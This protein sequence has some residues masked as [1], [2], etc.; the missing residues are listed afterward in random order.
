MTL[1]YFTIC[2]RNYLAYA[3]TLRASLLAAVPGAQFYIFLADEPVAGG[4]PCDGIIPAAA[5]AGFAAFSS[6]Q[7]ETTSSQSAPARADYAD[8]AFR[9]T[10]MEFN[11]AVK[12]FAFAH[13]FDRLGVDAAIYLDP[14]ILV[15]RPLEAVTDALAAGAEAI[16]TP[17]LTAPLADGLSPSD[18]D[19]ARAGV[20]NLGFAA[21]ANRPE[22]RAFIRWWAG[23][24]ATDCFV[25]LERGLFVDQKFCE[26]A[27][28]MIEKTAILADPGLNVAYWNLKHRPVARGP[29]GWTAAGA[30]LVF[31]HF[32]GVVPGDPT[33]FSKHQNRFSPKDL[34][35][36]RALFAEYLARLEANG[37]KRWR[38]VPYAYDRYTDG[39]PIPPAA[40]RLYARGGG[41]ASRSFSPLPFT[42]EG[43]ARLG[44]SARSDKRALFAPNYDALNALSAD[45]VQDEGAP[46]TLF[47]RE[48][49][50]GRADLQAAFPLSSASGRRGFCRWFILNGEKEARASEILLAP[51]RAAGAGPGPLERAAR[52]IYQKLPEKLRRRR[53]K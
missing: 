30:P 17:H 38:D 16:F 18:E 3:L 40:R 43:D 24:C 12:P 23:R 37:H 25:D 7:P 5:L 31:F 29:D 52:G 8:M 32:S 39:T 2:A 33:V 44:E 14:D 53:R 50:L 21:F 20:F 1:A 6:D 27:P 34:G 51:A 47:M 49:W 48:V 22:A 35:P 4:D 46:V 15:L 28:S 13:L 10:V 36:G 19:I 11:T 42:G 9:Y 26:R 41:A 45:V